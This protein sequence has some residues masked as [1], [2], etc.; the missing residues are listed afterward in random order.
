MH[1][2][3]EFFQLRLLGNDAHGSAHRA[4][5][6]SV[7][8]A[9]RAALRCGR[10]RARAVDRVRKRRVVDVKPVTLSPDMPRIDTVRA[11]PTPSPVGGER[12]VR[13]LGGVIKEVVDRFL[14]Q[15]LTS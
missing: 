1:H 5:T 15:C 2:G 14:L 12:Q 13:N 8:P 7:C 10:Y 6:V 3:G 4:R 9:G 11:V